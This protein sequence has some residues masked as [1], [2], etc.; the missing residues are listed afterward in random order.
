MMALLVEAGEPWFLSFER[1]ARIATAETLRPYAFPEPELDGLL[2]APEGFLPVWRPAEF[3]PGGGVVVLYYGN[4]GLAGLRV[5][6]VLGVR[7]VE[8]GAAHAAWLTTS[9]GRRGRWFDIDALERR[10]S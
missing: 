7:E 10:R 9:D 6:Q 8:E 1:V 4:D 5:T 2:F 3:L